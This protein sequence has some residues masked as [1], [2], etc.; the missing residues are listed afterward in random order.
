MELNAPADLRDRSG[1]I[2]SGVSKSLPRPCPA[3]RLD[4]LSR[5]HARPF[6]VLFRKARMD[7]SS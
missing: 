6:Y 2:F 5:A 4:D 1:A 7:K 3:S